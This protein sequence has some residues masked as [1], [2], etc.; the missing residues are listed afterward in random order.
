M[1]ARHQGL[2]NNVRVLYRLLSGW[3]C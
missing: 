2:L 3:K 1:K